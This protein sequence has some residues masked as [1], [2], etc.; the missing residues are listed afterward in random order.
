MVHQ[1]LDG[2][3]VALAGL[4]ARPAVHPHERG[5]AGP[6]RRL[7][8][9]V[10]DR[11]NDHPV[12]RLEAHDL[13]VDEILGVDVLRKRIG[14]AHGRLRAELAH[15]EVARRT[16][17]VDVEREPG[18]AVGE[19]DG[20]DVAGGQLRQRD[21]FPRLRVEEVN[22]RAP[23]VVD[24][25]HAIAAVLR[26]SDE[27]RVPR[28]FLHVLGLPAG[29]VVLPDAR[30]LGAFVGKI[31]ERSGGWIELLRSVVGDPLVLRDELRVV[32]R[33]VPEIDVAVGRPAGL[34][35]G[36]PFPVR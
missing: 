18:L 14:Q 9:L 24:A 20:R 17:A 36:D 13:G 12:E 25:G 28:R 16:V 2:R 30:E 23:V 6:R 7:Q 31:V 32:G 15:V 22:D 19:A 8:G 21:L 26:E 4:S 35:E 3:A 29:R 1:V 11:R 33:R 5:D 10:I 27:E 34:H